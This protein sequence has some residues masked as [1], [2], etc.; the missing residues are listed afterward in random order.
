[1][2][3]RPGPLKDYPLLLK[4]HGGKLFSIS[5]DRSSIVP[6]GHT[7]RIA[8]AVFKAKPNAIASGCCV[9]QAKMFVPSES[10]DAQ[11]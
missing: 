2:R 6:V 11:R 1:M 3:Q 4:H 7:L 10:T 8:N 5:S 9:A